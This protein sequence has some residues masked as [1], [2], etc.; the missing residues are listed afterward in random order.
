MTTY[1]VTNKTR[2]AQAVRVAGKKGE[3]KYDTLRAGETKDL[4]LHDRNSV[5]VKAKE[6]AGVFEIKENRS[7]SAVKKD[8]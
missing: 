2:T 6:D 8:D 4:N 5:V 7:T 1:T 3:P